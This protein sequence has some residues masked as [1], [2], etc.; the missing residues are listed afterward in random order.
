MPAFTAL[1]TSAWMCDLNI[2]A[3]DLQCS[4]NHISLG[5]N[6]QTAKFF[7]YCS[8]VLQYVQSSVVTWWGLLCFIYYVW[9]TSCFMMMH[10]YTL[11]LS[12]LEWPINALLLLAGPSQRIQLPLIRSC[13]NVRNAKTDVCDSSQKFH[14][15]DVNL[16]ALKW[17]NY[18]CESHENTTHGKDEKL[19]AL[20]VAWT[21]PFSNTLDLIHN[22]AD[23]TLLIIFAFEC[24][25]PPLHCKFRVRRKVNKCHVRS[26]DVLQ[27][28]L[29]ILLW[30]PKSSSKSRG[31]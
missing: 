16:P 26:L 23:Q 10:R 3:L 30:T 22:H 12:E 18:N 25:L 15:D 28:L 4:T 21:A 11:K 17:H 1:F 7:V 19:N 6:I 14:T 27:N 31:R 9:R 24:I 29:L 20:V 13:Y 5:H 2:L 8:V